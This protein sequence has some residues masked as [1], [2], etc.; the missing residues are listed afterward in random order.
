M[1]IVPRATRAE[2]AAAGVDYLRAHESGLDRDGGLNIW[3]DT[4]DGELLTA[5]DIISRYV[6]TGTKSESNQNDNAQWFSAFLEHANTYLIEAQRLVR[7]NSESKSS[8][9]SGYRLFARPEARPTIPAVVER[10]QDFRKRLDDT[11]AQYGR[12]SQILD[13]SFPRRLI[14]ATDRLG[15]GE[16]QKRLTVLEQQTAE[17]MT[18]GILDETPTQPLPVEQL[19]DIDPTQSRVMTLYVS[20]T[21]QKL[22]ALEDLAKRTRLLLEIVNTKY[23]NKNIRLDRDAGFIAENDAGSKLHLGSLSSGEQQEIVLHYDLLFK[24]PTNTIVLIDEP[25]LSLHVAWQKRFLPDLLKIVK[26]SDFDAIVATHSPY[27]IGDRHELMVGLGGD[28]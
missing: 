15:A 6:H 4:R 13:Q 17:Y 19:G 11:M 3:E 18:I 28:E 7:I 5:S 1:T 27:I 9:L 25:E 22:L 21:E 8:S 2:V 10:S 26:L 23:R 20:D 24:V 16:L 12:Q 14:S